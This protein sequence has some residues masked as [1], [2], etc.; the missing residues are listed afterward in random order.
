MPVVL[1]YVP[2][3][4]I[5]NKFIYLNGLRNIWKQLPI[6]KTSIFYVSQKVIRELRKLQKTNQLCY[7]NNI[8]LIYFD[9]YTNRL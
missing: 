1:E 6:D 3:E 2:E 8:I 7:E 5:K 9:F 4:T